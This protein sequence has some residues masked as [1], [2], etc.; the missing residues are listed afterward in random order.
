M[1]DHRKRQRELYQSEAISTKSTTTFSAGEDCG[2]VCLT[3]ETRRL[4][5]TVVT[6]VTVMTS[7]LLLL[8]SCVEDDEQYLCTVIRVRRGRDGLRKK[9][10]KSGGAMWQR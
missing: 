10:R 7:L 1:K 3:L 2:F 8:R 9:K 5:S 6:I 4:V